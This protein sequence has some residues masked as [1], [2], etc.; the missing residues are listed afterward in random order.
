MNYIPNGQFHRILHNGL[1][2]YKDNPRVHK[3]K[4]FHN[5]IFQITINEVKGKKCL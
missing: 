5:K 1:Y 4:E 2:V 3:N